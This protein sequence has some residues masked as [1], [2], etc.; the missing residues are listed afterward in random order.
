MEA[1]EI[2]GLDFDCLGAWFIHLDRTEGI[3]GLKAYLAAYVEC[4]K[5]RREWL[6]QT[7]AELAAMNLMRLAK[8]VA[9]A[10]LRCLPMTDLQFCDYTTTANIHA[11]L[12]KQ[13]R[14]ANRKRQRIEALLRQA[15]LTFDWLGEGD[16]ELTESGIIAEGGN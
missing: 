4:G 12:Q 7:A 16:D 15:G 6:Q 3:K 5:C 9:K 14:Q 13:Q 11:W 10:A 1:T 2:T 8:P